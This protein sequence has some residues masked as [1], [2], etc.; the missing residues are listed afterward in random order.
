MTV[1][2]RT[3]HALLAAVA[4]TGIGLV[5]TA[6]PASAAPIRNCIDV[7][8]RDVGRGDNNAYVAEVQCLLNWS[9]Y[10][11]TSAP[12]VVDGDFGAKTEAAVKIFQRC[13]N[14]R[15][16][17]LVVDGRVGPKTAP[18]LEWWAASSSYIC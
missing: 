18:H 1:G 6:G 2:K 5:A 11:F 10:S 3:L 7:P 4:M 15:G 14:D 12:L 17:G 16:A 9:L 13:A 8:N